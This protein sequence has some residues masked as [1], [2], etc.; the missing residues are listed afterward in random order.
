[1]IARGEEGIVLSVIALLFFVG[2]GAVVI[3]DALGGQV[4]MFAT[5]YMVG[6]VSGAVLALALAGA[7]RR[8][9]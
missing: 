3:V 8:G 2:G 5:G 6:A 4:V 7:D 1:M 9:E